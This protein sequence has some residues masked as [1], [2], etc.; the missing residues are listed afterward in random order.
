MAKF[1]SVSG[2]GDMGDAE[3]A[4]CKLVVACTDSSVDLKVHEHSFDA[5]AL[6]VERLVAVDLHATA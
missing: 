2:N 5:V 1:E 3:E 4:V 6:F